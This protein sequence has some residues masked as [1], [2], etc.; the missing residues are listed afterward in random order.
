[1]ERNI[2]ILQREKRLPN[3]NEIFKEVIMVTT[4]KKESNKIMKFGNKGIVFLMEFYEM[5]DVICH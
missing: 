5:E 2:K 3:T 1:M 4:R